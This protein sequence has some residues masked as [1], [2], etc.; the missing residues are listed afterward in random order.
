MS[1][2]FRIDPYCKN[3]V[4]YATIVGGIRYFN[5]IFS[6]DK[7]RPCKAGYGCTVRKL[8]RKR[9]KHDEKA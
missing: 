6:C 3:C 1:E 2:G 5:Y 7:R 8:R 4:Y 9:E